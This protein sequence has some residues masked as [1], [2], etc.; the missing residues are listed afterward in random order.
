[1]QDTL[2][3]DLQQYY[4]STLKGTHLRDLLADNTRNELLICQ[5]E[6]LVFDYTHEK[7]DIKA[8]ELLEKLADSA[9]LAHRIEDQFKGVSR[10]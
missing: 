3:A 8:K 10:D 9:K 6:N 4:D 7:L 2:W 5:F 1:M